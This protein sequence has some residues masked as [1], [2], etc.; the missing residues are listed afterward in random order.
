MLTN[1]EVYKMAVDVASAGERGIRFDQVLDKVR[2]TIDG[3]VIPLSA[4]R[5]ISYGDYRSFLRYKNWIRTSAFNRPDAPLAQR[6]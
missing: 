6:W 3:A 5:K 1:A 4:L 2:T